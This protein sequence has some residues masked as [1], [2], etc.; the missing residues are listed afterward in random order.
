M[1]RSDIKAGEEY[2]FQ[3]GSWATGAYRA[4]V[5]DTEPV[6]RKAKDSTSFFVYTTEKADGLRVVFLDDGMRPNPQPMI[7]RASK[8]HEATFDGHYEGRPIYR[9]RPQD[10]KK[11][12]AEHLEAEKAGKR[13]EEK[14]KIEAEVRLASNQARIEALPEG[15]QRFFEASRY[16]S[17]RLLFR[18]SADDLL[19][20]IEEV[21]ERTERTCEGY[22]PDPAR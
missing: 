9:V 19:T 8:P 7:P 11:T 17:G 20:A 14:R 15:L 5:L 1:K 3:R 12:W 2:L 10:I 13:A 22:G 4:L 6:R 21:L 18:G 16:N